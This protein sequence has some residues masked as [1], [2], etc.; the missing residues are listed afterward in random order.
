M[1]SPGDKQIH[2]HFI[3][4]FASAYR[5][6]CCLSRITKPGPVSPF[7]TTKSR[8]SS[9][10][11]IVTKESEPSSFRRDATS[12]CHAPKSKLVSRLRATRRRDPAMH[13]DTSRR[14]LPPRCCPR[15]PPVAS[16]LPAPPSS[17]SS[18]SQPRWLRR[19]AAHRT[20][21]P[22]NAAAVARRM[23][24]P[25]SAVRQDHGA[26]L[27]LRSQHHVGVKAGQVPAMVDH[28]HSPGSV[29]HQ[30]HAVGRCPCRS[31]LAGGGARTELRSEM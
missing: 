21:L 5:Y 25:L 13:Y 15:V 1:R 7:V 17:R 19:S 2:P 29:D 9:P 22:A 24:T 27:L 3:R 16:A 26:H 23:N 12:L 10:G 31:P 4:Y 20:A 8:P 11:E 28:R 30:P 14:V 6:S 18:R